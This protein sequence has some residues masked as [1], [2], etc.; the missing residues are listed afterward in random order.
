[1]TKKENP[2]DS[3]K[4]GKLPD[5]EESDDQKEELA[6]NNEEESSSEESSFDSIGQYLREMKLVPLLNREGEVR[7]A[8]EM[9]RG[10]KII[11]KAFTSS[12]VFLEI[13]LRWFSK[14]EEEERRLDEI[15]TS[16]ELDSEETQKKLRSLLNPLIP[17]LSKLTNKKLPKAVS[18]KMTA[19]CEVL[20]DC[21]FNG[22]LSNEL[23]ATLNAL[24]RQVKLLGE[25][26]EKQ[27]KN[28]QDYDD[29]VM[30]VGMQRLEKRLERLEEKA[31][32]SVGDIVSTMREVRKGQMIAED[33][34]SSLVEANL[35]LVVSLAKK[36][37]NRGLPFMDLI[38][39]GNMGLMRAA[40]K[41]DY[42]KGYKFSTY[43]VWWIRQSITRAI[44]DQVRMIRIPV[45]QM[46]HINQINRTVRILARELDRE[47]TVDE[48][49]A[50]M[51]LPVE[52]VE[53][54][55]RMVLSPISLETP[56]GDG[57]Q[58]HVGDFIEDKDN[59][60]QTEQLAM[61]D[62]K[63]ETLKAL[64]TLSER[65]EIVLKMRFGI[66]SDQKEHTL[67]EIGR[68]MHITKE[69]IRQIEAR[70]IRKLRHPSRCKTLKH[71]KFND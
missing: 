19:A 64:K 3:K 30:I 59:L 10:E 70:A 2:I 48:V 42:R 33:A 20:S 50:R 15:I 61:E 7:L 9:E 49:A 43:A 55:L 23:Q 12:P 45:H 22:I 38:Q 53:E 1:M 25:Q 52:M 69:R 57:D 66:G 47:P 6:E 18:R 4:L 14:F 34:K 56:I 65:E 11:S 71:F 5:Q 60:P 40:E 62:L 27:L 39:E 44:T 31:D 21:K 63:E 41:F 54:N 51:N 13:I 8:K 37:I 17:H 67:E 16:F 24:Y 32:M 29:Q 46:D 28:E 58:N 35:R 68:M 26:L 36:Y